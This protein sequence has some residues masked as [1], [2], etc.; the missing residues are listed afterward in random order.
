[1]NCSSCNHRVMGLGCLL[2]NKR[3][4]DHEHCEKWE[5]L[6]NESIHDNAARIQ[7]FKAGK[8]LDLGESA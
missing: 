6:V 3:V 7:Y 1:M 5:K 8:I 2:T 4:T